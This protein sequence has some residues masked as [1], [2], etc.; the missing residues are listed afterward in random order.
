MT[1]T[2]LDPRYDDAN[3]PDWYCVHGQYTGSPWG[4]DFLCGM[5]ES[6]ITNLVTCATCE[7]KLWLQHEQRVVNGYPSVERWKEARF[8]RQVIA[9]IRASDT[10]MT[11]SIRNVILD[12]IKRIKAD[13]PVRDHNI[14]MS[15]AEW[16]EMNA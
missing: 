15:D 4:G 16:E 11:N 1:T 12:T 10:G 8:M 9:D 7:V 2:G 5:C 3:N 6:G 14:S 13:T